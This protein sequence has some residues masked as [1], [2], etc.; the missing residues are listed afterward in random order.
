MNG[1]EQRKRK[2]LPCFANLWNYT[3]TWSCT[4]IEIR[5]PLLCGLGCLPAME[6]IKMCIH[7]FLQS[8]WDILRYLRYF[9]ISEIF[10][11][12][13]DITSPFQICCSPLSTPS[14]CIWS[15]KLI[16]IDKS[17]RF[18]STI[19]LCCELSSIVS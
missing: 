13:W 9:E 8:I 5:S 3:A 2:F 10:W 1:S 18:R 6:L 7:W 4:T 19:I 12:I 15:L 17:D 16:L 14:H 11:D